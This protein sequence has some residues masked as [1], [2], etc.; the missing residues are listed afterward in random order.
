MPPTATG[1]Q[2]AAPADIALL[3]A[4]ME[5]FYRE[6]D[7]PLDHAWATRSFAKLLGDPALG[8]VWLLRCDGHAAG[9]AVLTVRFS[10]EYGHRRFHRRLVRAAQHRRRGVGTAAMAE[11]LA[12]CRRRGAW[13]LHVEVAPDNAAAQALYRKFGL[14]PGTDKRQMLTVELG[15]PDATA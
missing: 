1:V 4:C 3:V 15:S 7:Y 8:A 13:A 14:R 9:H 5:E 6:A 2:R 12:E 11:L 10:M